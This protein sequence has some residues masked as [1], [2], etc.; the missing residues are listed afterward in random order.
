[1]DP[2]L[3]GDNNL[4]PH[5]RRRRSL[6]DEDNVF[7]DN[8]L[9][10]EK[11]VNN[12]PCS[13]E[14]SNQYSQEH[15]LIRNLKFYRDETNNYEDLDQSENDENNIRDKKECQCTGKNCK[16]SRPQ[17]S[18]VHTDDSNFVYFDGALV[19]PEQ[20]FDG[21]QQD[22]DK[23]SM[24]LLPKKENN[25]RLNRQS[26]RTQT[27]ILRGLK[28]GGYILDL[29]PDIYRITDENPNT[30]EARKK[31]NSFVDLV[32]IHGG[33]P[34]MNHLVAIRERSMLPRLRTKRNSDRTQQLV[35]SEMSDEDLF[36]AL[37]QGFD[38]ELA[39]YKRV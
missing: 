37:P 27:N 26:A 11:I 38:G 28:D 21:I 29:D 19:M 36:G 9:R 1:M 13:T 32:A 34:V 24:R 14:P 2:V 31:R 5:I 7:D 8:P 15:F 39:R 16:C 33:G 12:V 30:P 18:S 20:P 23:A 10:R 4:V 3:S 6:D 17:K 35:L 25:K 22:T